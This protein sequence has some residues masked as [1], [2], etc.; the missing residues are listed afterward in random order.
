MAAPPPSALDG[1]QVLQ[2]AFID[3]TGEIRVASTIY[4]Q[5][6]QVEVVIDHTEDSVRLGNG[7]S[8]FTSTTVNSDLGLDTYIIN[9]NLDIRDLNATQDNV[10]IS[11]G[12]NQLVINPDGSINIIYDPSDSPVAPVNTFN[13]VTAVPASVDTTVTTYTAP[14]AKTTY[15]QKVT[16]SGTNIAKYEVKVNGVVIDRKRTFF[17]GPF[18]VEFEFSNEVNNGYPLSVGDV[19]TLVVNHNRGSTGDFES[20]IQS[21]EI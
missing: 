19:V 1:N 4:A 7:T 15:L 11:D 10:A 18:D 17:S 5:I 3:A 21:I 9:E 6:G 12:T 14:V 13:D 2:H 8:F 20:R 16:A